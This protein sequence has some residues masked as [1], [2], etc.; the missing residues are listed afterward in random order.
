MQLPLQITFRDMPP[1]EAVENK[2]REKAA[3]LDKFFDRIMAC[4][5]SVEA[6]HAHQNKGK[7]FHIRIDITVPN[8]EIVVSRDNHDDHAHEDIYVA[9]R[10]A[11]NAAQR[12]LQEY[13]AKIRRDIKSH[14]VPPHGRVMALFP[15]MEYGTIQTPDGREIY[16]HKN[17]VLSSE[18]ERLEVGRE[19]RF[20]EEA[21]DEGPQASTVQVVGKHHIVE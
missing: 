4:R 18:F 8:G 12:Q 1:S 19:V 10:D 5:V 7:L 15:E 11:F 17:S 9:I 21:G 13:A 20:V 16:F 3:K 2:I 6:P 14:D